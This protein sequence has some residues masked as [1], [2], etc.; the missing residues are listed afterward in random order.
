MA[1]VTKTQ[2]EINGK[3]FHDF[4]ELV[5][6]E[7]MAAHHEFEM[8]CRM[9]K[10]ESQDSMFLLDSKNFLGGEIKIT[11]EPD[12]NM[13]K[14]S[15]FF[16]G[17]ITEVE[18]NRN[19]GSAGDVIIIRGASPDIM[20]DGC[21]DSKL[22]FNKNTGQIIN[23]VISAYPLQNPKVSPKSSDSLPYTVQYNESDYDFV[24]RM[25][26][27]KGEW[28]YYDGNQLQIG[29]LSQKTEE[30]VYGIDL[31]DF[32]FSVRLEPMK[33]KY[34]AFG[35]KQKQMYKSASGG[36]NVD[37]NQGE[38]GKF[39][40]KK[41]DKIYLSETTAFYNQPL[42]EGNEQKHLDDRVKLEK[43]SRA[44]RLAKASGVSDNLALALGKKIKVKALMQDNKKMIDYGEYLITSITHS[45]TRTG[46]YTNN[47]SV[48][49]ASVQRP[50]ETNPHMTTYCETQSALV[51]HND[52]PDSLGRIKVNFQW[53]DGFESPWLRIV[54]PYA[55]NEKGLYM[56][57]EVGEEVLVAFEKNNPEKPYVLGSMYN[58]IEKPSKWKTK[59]NDYK[60]IRTR[61]GHTIEFNDKQGKEEIVIY[62][63]DKV[64]TITLS[65]HGKVMTISCKGDL[66][67]KA[68]NIEISAQ[69]DYKLEVQGKIDVSSMKDTEIKATGNCKM[70]AN[71][72]VSIEGATGL[73]AKSNAA[74]E[75]SGMTLAAKGSA[76]AEFSAGG[77]TVVKGAIVMIN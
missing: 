75:V 9:D 62:D 41:S 33:I 57:P 12:V 76:T 20:M 4:V 32:D 10:L 44:V 51:T 35:F 54:S 60:A 42:K 46:H 47:F 2:I 43:E 65:S 64:N 7:R 77:Q 13:R 68:Q 6:H 67:I 11:I 24:A 40:Y 38:I 56:I 19:F 23:D 31:V 45:C 53:G 16:R 8:I 18:A 5:I 52:D 14:G 74:T 26:A 1:I 29:Q 73:T 22:F 66:K 49:P 17:I 36:V 63:K 50:P 72:K 34:G 59:D 15:V 70:K 61:S 25:C 58:G 30:L 27:R 39:A 55:G 28:F 21:K 48:L 71:Q 3:T 37:S 69:K